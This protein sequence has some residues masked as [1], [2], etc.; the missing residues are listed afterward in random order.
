MTDI[1][2]VA[3]KEL[4]EIIGGGSGRKGRRNYC[5]YHKCSQSQ[6]Q[7]QQWSMVVLLVGIILLV[8]SY[9]FT[10]CAQMELDRLRNEIVAA[11]SLRRNV[12]C[13]LMRGISKYL[14]IWPTLCRL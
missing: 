7:G 9:I 10:S 12:V 14:F 3:R 2:T 8:Y 1:L 5:L 6:I 11:S 4:R 13:A